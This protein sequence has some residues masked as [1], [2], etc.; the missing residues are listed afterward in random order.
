MSIRSSTTTDH[1]RAGRVSCGR[2]PSRPPTAPREKHIRAFS[3]L[4]LLVVLAILA[5]ASTIM[6]P[7]FTGS[8]GAELKAAASELASGLR[9][10]RSQALTHG[11]AVTLR[12]DVNGR[13]FE[14]SGSDVWRDLP[15]S[16]DLSLYTARTELLDGNTAAI[17][18]FPDGSSTGGR[19]TVTGSNGQARYV[20]V[21]WL[22]GRVLVIEEP[23]RREAA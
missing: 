12:L 5:L 19:I 11:D 7:A 1:S 15:S 14:V 8:S 16:V 22:T 13:R 17:R 18:F 6:I 4:E 9:Y 3:L 2:P 23:E 21:D 10:A 20:D